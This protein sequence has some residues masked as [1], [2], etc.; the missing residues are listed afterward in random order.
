MR[1]LDPKIEWQEELFKQIYK[2]LQG[3]VTAQ[4]RKMCVG[5]GGDIGFRS[6]MEGNSL[7]VQKDILP[8]LYTLCEEVK[9]KLGFAD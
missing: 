6:L 7:K 4:I 5:N 1:E 9:V 8:D 2:V 3:D